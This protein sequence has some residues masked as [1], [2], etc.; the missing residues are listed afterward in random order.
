METDDEFVFCLDL[1]T[2]DCWKQIVKWAKVKAQTPKLKDQLR[3][4]AGVLDKKE[5]GE[6]DPDTFMRVACELLPYVVGSR[7]YTVFCMVRLVQELAVDEEAGAIINY[8]MS[9]FTG[10]VID[11]LQEVPDSED[12]KNLLGAVVD[13]VRLLLRRGQA[14]LAD[15]LCLFLTVAGAEGTKLEVTRQLMATTNQL[16][17]PLQRAQRSAVRTQLDDQLPAL[18]R[19]LTTCGDYDVQASLVDGLM[20]QYR[21]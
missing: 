14:A 21:T 2:Q 16:L 3:G 20:R 18:L 7:P 17:E 10:C 19:L 13:V 12:V 4:C 9:S 11:Y 5:F 1:S 8:R 6:V 15:Y